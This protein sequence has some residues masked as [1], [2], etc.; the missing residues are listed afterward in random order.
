M[1][2]KGRVRCALDAKAISEYLAPLAEHRPGFIKLKDVSRPVLRDDLVK[3]AEFIR[4]ARQMDPAMRFSK[5]QRIIALNHVAARFCNWGLPESQMKDY[6]HVMQ[7]RWYTLAKAVGKAT[8]RPSPP[9]WLQEL[10]A[11]VSPPRNTVPRDDGPMTLSR[12]FHMLDRDEADALE[13]VG[14]AANHR[15]DPK[16]PHIILTCVLHRSLFRRAEGKRDL[17]FCSQRTRGTD[18]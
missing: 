11:P 14:A 5:A 13:V 3:N 9:A 2:P 18:T 6:V 15:P 17:F 16:L 10:L 12:E 1:A 7:E 8:R 4:V